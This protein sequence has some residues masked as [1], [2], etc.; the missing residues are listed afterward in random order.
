[1]RQRSHLYSIAPTREYPLRMHSNPQRHTVRLL[2]THTHARPHAR[3]HTSVCSR[4]RRPLRRSIACAA[5]MRGVCDGA[6]SLCNRRHATDDMPEWD[7]QRTRDKK[8]RR[9]RVLQH[10]TYGMRDGT[11]NETRC[12][13]ERATCNM[14]RTTRNAEHAT[15]RDATWDRRQTAHTTRHRGTGAGGRKRTRGNVHSTGSNGQRAADDTQG[16]TCKAPQE[17]VQQTP[18]NLQHA[19]GKMQQTTR[20]MHPTT[21][22]RH[23]P[24]S[25]QY[26]AN[27][28]RPATRNMQHAPSSEQQTACN[29]TCSTQ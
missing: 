22:R 17:N 14:Q 12:D 9:T 23:A 25:G 19:T 6:V 2:P 18:R 21:S 16:T 29:A 27:S 24:C 13:W 28:K 20:I 11:G 5:A 4:S 8:Q 26:T 15:C 1:M 7:R 10:A 3:T